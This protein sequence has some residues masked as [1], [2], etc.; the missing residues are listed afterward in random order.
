M[1]ER[2][3]A[4]IKTC[5]FT[6]NTINYVLIKQIATHTSNFLV[7]DPSLSAPDIIQ[8]VAPKN[9]SP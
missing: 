8:R 7:M 4:S 6:T 9:V 5:N 1:D 2:G 3:I